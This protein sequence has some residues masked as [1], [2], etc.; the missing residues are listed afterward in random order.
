MKIKF[1]ATLREIVG[2]KNVDVS[3]EPGTSAQELLNQLI[4]AFPR[5]RAELLDE[6]GKLHGHVHFFING[7]DVQFTDAGFET[8]ITP[9]DVINIF[10]AVGGG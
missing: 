2:G 8:E 5:L 3:L 4:D 6:T 7:R 10:P 1:F 9:D